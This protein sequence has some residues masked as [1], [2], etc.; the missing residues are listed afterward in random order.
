M[1]EILLE[2]TFGKHPTEKKITFENNISYLSESW[3]QGDIIIEMKSVIMRCIP[4]FS[5]GFWI[6]Q[7][8]KRIYQELNLTPV[9][10]LHCLKEDDVI[11]DEELS[12]KLL[13]IIQGGE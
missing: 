10:L 9:K 3:S 4:K 7:T 6:I 1:K 13:K 2:K 5:E 12:L 8:P 11:V